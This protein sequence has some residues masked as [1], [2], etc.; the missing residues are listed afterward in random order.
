VP[1]SAQFAPNCRVRDTVRDTVHRNP[2]RGTPRDSLVLQP[3]RSSPT[4]LSSASHPL[5]FSAFCSVRSRRSPAAAAT[6]R[7]IQH[8]RERRSLPAS[9]ATPRLPRTESAGLL[10][11]TRSGHPLRHAKRVFRSRAWLRLLPAP[12][13]RL[14]HCDPR[15]G[16]RD[17]FPRR[18]TRN[19]LLREIRCPWSDRVETAIPC[20]FWGSSGARPTGFEPVT[21][22]FVDLVLVLLTAGRGSG[23][24]QLGVVARRS[25][26]RTERRIGRSYVPEA[27]ARRAPVGGPRSARSHLLIVR[28]RC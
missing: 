4:S 11:R 27:L 3:R 26:R 1:R 16:L 20:G 13:M 18:E 21:F 28:T 9:R 6:G 25:V 17:G 12:R 14:Q 10:Q 5:Q 8:C 2:P 15:D 19:R 7:P 24:T 22:G 23:P